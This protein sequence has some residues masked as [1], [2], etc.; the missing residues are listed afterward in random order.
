MIKLAIACPHLMVG[1]VFQHDK[2]VLS[3]VFIG[4]FLQTLKDERGK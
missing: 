4:G 3:K 1:L 2:C